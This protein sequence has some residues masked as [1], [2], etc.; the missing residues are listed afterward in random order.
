MLLEG[1]HSGF[2]PFEARCLLEIE[3]GRRGCSKFVRWPRS[4][5][6][7]HAHLRPSPTALPPSTGSRHLGAVEFPARAKAAV[8]SAAGSRSFPRRDVPAAPGPERSFG[9]CAQPLPPCPALR[10]LR[11]GRGNL[12][13]MTFVGQI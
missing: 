13:G 8:P 9:S 4:P 3:F 2:P 5:L 1:N 11:L 10:L 12:L 6:L 7:P